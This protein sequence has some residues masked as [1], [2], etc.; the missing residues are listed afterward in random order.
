MHPLPTHAP[1]TDWLTLAQLLLNSFRHWTGRELL[2]RTSAAEDLLA[3]WNFPGVIVAHG[4]QIDPA[5]IFAN[6]QATQLWDLPLENFLG[7][8][9]RLTAE[10]MHRDERQQ[11]LDRTRQFGF[12]D[13][14]RG[15]RISRTGKR[16]FIEQATLWMVLDDQ[17]Q[18]IGQAA[19]FDQWTP[20]PSAMR[21][22]N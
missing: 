12:V 3:M 9:S 22:E 10:P 8:P 15:V 4:T 6:F 11:L 20:L 5:F 18:I 13:D 14:Y 2:H 16:F 17:D 7:M 19:T 1:L 21:A